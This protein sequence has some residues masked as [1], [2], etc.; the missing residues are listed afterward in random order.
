MHHPRPLQPTAT[1]STN[2]QLK[3]RDTPR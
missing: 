2:K 3:S 1:N